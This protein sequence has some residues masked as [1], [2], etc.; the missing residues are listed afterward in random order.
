[1]FRTERSCRS[2]TLIVIKSLPSKACALVKV[3]MCVRAVVLRNVQWGDSLHTALT[4]AVCD[5][6]RATLLVLKA[7]GLAALG[8]APVAAG[9]VVS[10]YVGLDVLQERLL[11]VRKRA[12]WRQ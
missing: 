1:M 12:I 6:Q 9:N 5:M 8:T 10:A 11:Q 2:N 3:C 4:T 7:L